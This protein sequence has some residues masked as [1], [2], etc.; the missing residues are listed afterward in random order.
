[1]DACLDF[2]RAFQFGN[3]VL[4]FFNFERVGVFDILDDLFKFLDLEV[5]LITYFSSAPTKFNSVVSFTSSML[6][7]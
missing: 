3:I 6:S 1:M 7:P 4:E 2:D 5:L